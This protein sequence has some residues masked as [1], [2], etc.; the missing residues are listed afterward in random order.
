MG[1]SIKSDWVFYLLLITY[2][3]LIISMTVQLRLQAA[4]MCSLASAAPC[5]DLPLSAFRHGWPL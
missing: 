5:F 4:S 1:Y 2:A 3:Y